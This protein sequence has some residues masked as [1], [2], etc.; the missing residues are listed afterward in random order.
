MTEPLLLGQKE[1][2]QVNEDDR[3]CLASAD[4][5][6]APHEPAR[7]Y[8]AG[9]YGA[10]K[11]HVVPPGVD[12]D[13]FDWEEGPAPAGPPRVLYLGSLAPGRGVRVLLRAWYD[14][15]RQSDA[16]LV[17]AGR[18]SPEFTRSLQ[19]AMQDSAIAKSVEYLGEVEHEQVAAL[20]A[21]A[22]VCV[23]PGAVELGA[24]PLGLFPTKLLEYLACKRAVVAPARSSVTLIMRDEE[25]GLL[26]EPGQPEQLAQQLLRLLGDARLRE[27]L[28]N[29]GY[30]MVRSAH[31]ASK[32]RRELRAAY[33]WLAAQPDWRERF[34]SDG[35]AS[36]IGI[37]LTSPGEASPGT[38]WDPTWMMS[39]ADGGLDD[40]ITTTS[41]LGEEGPGEVTKVEQHPLA[42]HAEE[43]AG[44]RPGRREKRDTLTDIRD[45]E[46]GARPPGESSVPVP[47][48]TGTLP[49]IENRFVAGELDIPAPGPVGAA[50][51]ASPS[52]VGPVIGFEEVDIGNPTV[53]VDDMELLEEEDSKTTVT[54][55]PAAGAPVRPR[56]K[57][58]GPSTPPPLPPGVKGARPTQARPAKES[59]GAGPAGKD[60]TGGSET[61]PSE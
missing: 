57:R 11:V 12:V 8:L 45:D 5:I 2:L 35:D 22:T 56:G 10:N 24:E 28:A 29:T 60:G 14:V 21:G 44:A 20:I 34:M 23:A 48:R 61:K 41:E 36:S 38:D 32:S 53:F 27:R 42:P 7:R 43:L 58:R 59:A 49:G 13:A 16:R 40:D 6:L 55:P 25:H 31:T 3:R 19:G 15:S 33:D 4:M 26:F 50:A 18:S 47:V 9:R 52:F 17:L 39:G 54:A 37:S 51:S 30:Q 46:E 1:A